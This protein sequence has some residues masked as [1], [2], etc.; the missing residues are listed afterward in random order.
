METN[1]CPL[2]LVLSSPSTDPTAEGGKV[3]LDVGFQLMHAK[4]RTMT[5][6]LPFWSG[7]RTKRW[8]ETLGSQDGCHVCT[9]IN[10]QET[11][12]PNTAGQ[13]LCRWQNAEGEIK[14]G[15]QAA[16]GVSHELFQ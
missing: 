16:G 11:C 10:K 4:T 15:L 9:H 14:R 7:L 2:P 8:E 12:P 3:C 1:A 5:H 13:V 6:P